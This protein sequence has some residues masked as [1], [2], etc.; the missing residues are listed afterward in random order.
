[1]RDDRNPRLSRRPLRRTPLRRLRE[2]PE[3]RK[4]SLA[5][6]FFSS[7]RYKAIPASGALGESSTAIAA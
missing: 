7:E 2:G 1:M 5:V 3:V 4:N 6:I